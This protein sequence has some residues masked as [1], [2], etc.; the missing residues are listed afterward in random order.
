MVS[1]AA[2]GSSQWK[3]DVFWASG[4]RPG[5]RWGISQSLQVSTGQMTTQG[6]QSW[7]G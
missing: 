1:R 3:V 4:S 7:P 2:L 6:R 5:S